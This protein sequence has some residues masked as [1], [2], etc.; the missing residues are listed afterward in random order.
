VASGGAP[1]PGSRS[2]AASERG[3]SGAVTRGGKARAA[4][5]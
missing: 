2:S 4:R 3:E 5:S 1:P